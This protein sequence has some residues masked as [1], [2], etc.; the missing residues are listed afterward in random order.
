M[1]E[2][3][4][5]AART[6]LAFWRGG[7]ARPLA[8][9]I[10]LL[11]CAVASSAHA[12]LKLCN[13]MSYVVDAAVGTDGRTSTSRG[14]YRLDPGQCT[15]IV[16]GHFENQRL[17]LH[18]RTL[19]VYGAAP[20]TEGGGHDRLCVGTANFAISPARQC[21]SGQTLASFTEVQPSVAEG[22][23]QIAYLSEEADYDDDQARLAGIQRLLLIAGYDT[24]PI[25]GIDGPKTQAALTSFL[26]S[27]NLS[28]DVIKSVDFFESMIKAVEAP[29]G[30]G[31]TWCN[32]TPHR[33][34]AALATGDGKA[35]TSRG[36][37]RIEPG[38]CVHPDVTGDPRQIFSFAEA[39]D[40]QGSAIT[41]GGK[42]LKWG[43]ATFF[44]TRNSKFEAS[45]HND[46]TSLGFVPTGF[47][48]V[49]P[50]LARG[51]QPLRFRMP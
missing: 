39:V 26:S 1:T 25:D 50:A 2:I 6:R 22:G 23:E 29:T 51:E 9:A 8:A 28:P 30:K 32:D 21:R 41:T 34:M 33:V 31:L 7:R 19:P 4:K 3:A 18:V 5:G 42:P 27:R 48:A 47:V 38:K 43:G 44:C 40:S 45:Q 11:S 13:Q 24:A 15:A 14:W 17:L 16:E 12:D 46:C 35:I 49:E 37:Y 20:E 36:W 10:A